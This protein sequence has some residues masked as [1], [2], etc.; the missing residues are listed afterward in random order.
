MQEFVSRAD[1]TVV[2]SRTV[3]GDNLSHDFFVIQFMR[4]PASGSLVL[5]VQGFWL[6]GTTAASFFMVN[7]VLPALSSFDKAWYA[8]EWTDA[9]GDLAPDLNEITLK[10]SGR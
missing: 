1:G 10:A 8:Y 9:N 7:G 4:D 2:V 6:S 3:A 5:N